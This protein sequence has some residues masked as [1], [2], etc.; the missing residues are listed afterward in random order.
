MK[1]FEEKFI[2]LREADRISGYSAGYL[3]YLARQGKLKAIKI[4]KS[5]LTTREWLNQFLKKK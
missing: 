4:G 1:K 2:T 5:W 3:A